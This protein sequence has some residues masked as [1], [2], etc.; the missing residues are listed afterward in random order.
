MRLLVLSCSIVFF[1]SGCGLVLDTS[2]PDVRD[3]G[4][5]PQV[6]CTSHEDCNDGNYCNG[7]ED[8]VLGFCQVIGRPACN[9][10]IECTNDVCD[11]ALDTCRHEPVGSICG[12]SQICQPGTGCV[13][14]VPCMFDFDCDDENAC[15]IG[16]R[17]GPDLHC[18]PGAVRACPSVGCLRGT[19]NE[20]NGECEQVQDDG[21][22]E[23][24]LMCTFGTCKSDG[25]CEQDLTDAMCGDGVGCTED[26]CVGIRVG[27][28]DTTGCLHKPD[29]GV[30][31]NG[32]DACFERVCAPNASPAGDVTGCSIRVP[33]R[34]CNDDAR[35]NTGT[36]QCEALP[37]PPGCNDGNP[38]NGLESASSD[39]NSCVSTGGCPEPANGC[40]ESVC[41]FGVQLGCGFR[42]NP[43]H[44]DLCIDTAAANAS[45]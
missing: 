24:G 37:R 17:C 25:F 7:F 22:C 43:D 3:S 30:C 33:P 45:F 11:E 21:A 6:Q 13:A 19:C 10:G 42:L 9:D 4:S 35:C 40:F 36:G 23:D 27:P 5:L 26:R 41:V 16:E 29:D 31:D 15:T 1:A 34:A 38:C 28:N 39:G 18:I 12:P 20:D 2:P 32:Q 8:C 44:I 14:R